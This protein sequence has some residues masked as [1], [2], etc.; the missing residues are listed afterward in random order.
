MRA[1]CRMQELH[2]ASARLPCPSWTVS[3]SVA[4]MVR[5]ERQDPWL[6]DRPCR[7]ARAEG[8]DDLP[9]RHGLAV[10]AQDR[11]AESDTDLVGSWSAAG[12]RT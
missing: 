8:G 11:D 10:A 4:R 1:D 5:S 7:L 12:T 6:V 9:E 3:R 2:R